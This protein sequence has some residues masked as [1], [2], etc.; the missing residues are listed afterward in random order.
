[1]KDHTKTAKVSNH[2]LTGCTQLTDHLM[3]KV[4]NKNLMRNRLEVIQ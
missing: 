3:A 4:L 1:M 2:C